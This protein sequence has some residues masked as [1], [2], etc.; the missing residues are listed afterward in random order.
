MGAFSDSINANIEK[1]KRRTA[2][3]AV[4]ITQELFYSI[5]NKT[6][7]LNGYLIN[8]WFTALGNNYSSATTTIA[9]KTGGG[10][11]LNVSSLSQHNLFYGKDHTVT[12]ANNLHYGY[13]IEYL[14]WSRVKAPYGMV[15]ISLMDVAAKHR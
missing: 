8:N 15:R 1:I 4:K 9:D 10:S 3:N 12:M 11:K 7:V 14:G 2:D 6:P 13:Q 5:I